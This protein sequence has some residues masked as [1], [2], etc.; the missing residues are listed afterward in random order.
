MFPET[1]SWKWWH[2]PWLLTLFNILHFNF[3][4]AL[5]IWIK[6]RN[7]CIWGRRLFHLGTKTNIR[8]SI[9]DVDRDFDC[10]DI[11]VISSP[12]LSIL[13]FRI[14]CFVFGR[15]TKKNCVLSREKDISQ[16]L[17]YINW[18]N[19]LIVK[20]VIRPASS[21]ERAGK[22]NLVR[23]DFFSPI[24]RLRFSHL[25]SVFEIKCKIKSKQVLARYGK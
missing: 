3:L 13:F 6:M 15:R 12:N 16:W 18:K 22:S 25:K 21:R 7:V 4:F 23:Y 2:Q 20:K 11:S 8:N 9:V 24:Y 17:N 5:K 10:S 19:K 1:Y 14:G